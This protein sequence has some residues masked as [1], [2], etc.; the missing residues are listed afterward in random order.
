L[1]VRARLDVGLGG[2]RRPRLFDRRDGRPRVFAERARGL[3]EPPRQGKALACGLAGVPG[4][5]IVVLTADGSIDP[6]EI[7]LFVDPLLEGADFIRGSLAQGSRFLFGGGNVN[8]TGLRQGSL[9]RGLVSALFGKQ[10]TDLYYEIRRG[11]PL[12]SLHAGDP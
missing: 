9:L 5:I 10:C 4:G 2:D 8:I 1:R 11:A 6:A 3:S 12:R 7:R